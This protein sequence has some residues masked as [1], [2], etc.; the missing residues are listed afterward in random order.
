MTDENNSDLYNLLNDLI[1]RVTNLE[2]QISSMSKSITTE[3]LTV[4]G[5]ISTGTINNYHIMN[6]NGG[7]ENDTSLKLPVIPSIR[8]DGVM[9]T[10]KYL[11]FHDNTS[12][13]TNDYSCRITCENKKLYIGFGR[14]KKE[15]ATK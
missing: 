2:K 13:T 6:S 3:S 9:E 12:D 11:D 8:D 14:D 4:S 10:G 1:S 7:S 5:N 15:I